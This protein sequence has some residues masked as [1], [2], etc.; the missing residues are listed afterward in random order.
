M[1]LGS[2]FVFGCWVTLS[3]K[4]QLP[5]FAVRWSLAFCGLPI[6]CS[7]PHAFKSDFQHA[8][9]NVSITTSNLSASLVYSPFRRRVWNSLTARGERRNM[10][11]V[12]R[13]RSQTRAASQ[14]W[15]PTRNAETTNGQTLNG[16]GSVWSPECQAEP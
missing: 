7:T 9:N 8:L 5:R 4:P 13:E 6:L 16:D 11:M 15:T 14:R 2:P 1:L 3:L 12:G 10:R